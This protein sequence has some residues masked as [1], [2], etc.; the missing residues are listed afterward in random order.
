MT[1]RNPRGTSNDKTGQEAP[2][3]AAIGVRNPI[4]QRIQRCHDPRRL[5]LDVRQG[6][7]ILH[8]PERAEGAAIW[9]IDIARLAPLLGQKMPWQRREGPTAGMGFPF[10]KAR[11]STPSTVGRQ[12]AGRLAH[13][14]ILNA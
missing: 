9:T 2:T 10:N 4:N 7:R 3:E 13:R 14:P 12:H 6:A 1:T 5:L 11:R 8:L